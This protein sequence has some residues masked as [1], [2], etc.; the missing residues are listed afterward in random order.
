MRWQGQPDAHP[1][2]SEVQP[3]SQLEINDSI[4]FSNLRKK[5]GLFYPRVEKWLCTYRR[6][7][8]CLNILCKSRVEKWLCTYRRYCLCF[9]ILCKSRVEKWMCTY[10]RYCLCFNII[11][12]KS[13]FS[14]S[15]AD[16]M[17]VIFIPII[18]V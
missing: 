13:R 6:Y 5:K 8:L 1:L 9:N 3:S 11:L 15:A 10:R 7:C 12:C 2:V 14:H 17:K 16:I 4:K 18:F